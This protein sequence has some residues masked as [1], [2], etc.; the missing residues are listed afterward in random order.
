VTSIY[1]VKKSEPTNKIKSELNSL[2]IKLTSTLSRA[3][4]TSNE[5]T[6]LKAL[7]VLKEALEKDDIK[8]PG[9]WL[10]SAIEGGWIKNEILKQH[11]K[12]SLHNGFEQWYKIGQANNNSSDFKSESFH[13]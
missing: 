4:K 5:E 6:V 8:S 3:I 2:G 10:K 7:E 13:Y 1:R 12:S 11:D 9:G